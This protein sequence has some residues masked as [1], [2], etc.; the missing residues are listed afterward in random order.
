MCSFGNRKIVGIV[1]S[2][3][4]TG[5]VP[6]WATAQDDDPFKRQGISTYP[7]PYYGY[8]STPYGD[9]IRAYGDF[10]IKQQQAFML[11]EH[12]RQARIVTRR[13]QLEHW[14]WEREYMV[15]YDNRERARYQKASTEYA[16][17]FATD[18]EILEGGPL[19]RL[20]NDLSK[21]VNYPT[22]G[23]VAVEKKWL[24]DINIAIAGSAN[25]GVLKGDQIY[26]PPLLCRSSFAKE[27]D[28]IDKLLERAKTA[29]RTNASG[30]QKEQD[31]VVELRQLV[32][33][34]RKRLRG[35]LR[36][37]G[38]PSWNCRYYREAQRFLDQVDDSI[39]AMEKRDAS[40]YFT[41][42]QGNN[43]AE[44][45]AYMKKEGVDIAPAT[46]GS[47]RSYRALYKALANELRR[48]RGLEGGNQTQ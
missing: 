5:L 48:V 4:A 10:M 16:L 13:Q 37:G 28:K 8:I 18:P 22:S 7:S 38:D 2:L 32:D 36:A 35:G 20:Y 29:V 24:G 30:L 19:R 39:T 31:L 41:S 43:V 6:A 3:L 40:A 42:L 44:L 33:D 17:E 1:I 27:H 11:R 21:R 9:A 46:L 26:W 15:N 23:S 14:E 12:V 47:E 25:A 45:V 34:C